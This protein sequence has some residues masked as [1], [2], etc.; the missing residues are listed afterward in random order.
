MQRYR[1]MFTDRW[2][3]QRKT[4]AN[5]NLDCQ[6]IKKAYI[7]DVPD[8]KFMSNGYGSKTHNSWTEQ[9]IGYQK[10]MIL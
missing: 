2:K 7:V 6:Q 8:P 10:I 4:D 5:E 9:Y 1:S 3:H